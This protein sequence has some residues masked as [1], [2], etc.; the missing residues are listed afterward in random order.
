M[1]YSLS[2]TGVGF[3]SHEWRRQAWYCHIWCTF[4]TL[5]CISPEI[6]WWLITARLK[7]TG[8]NWPYTALGHVET[9]IT[10]NAEWKRSAILSAMLGNHGVATRGR[11]HSALGGGGHV[12]LPGSTLYAPHEQLQATVC[13]TLNMLCTCNCDLYSKQHWSRYQIYWLCSKF[14]QYSGN[15]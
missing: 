5:D 13:C 6:A 10:G 9:G 7:D 11:V 8:T 2:G 14:W 15:I 3:L 4:G 1:T 12:K